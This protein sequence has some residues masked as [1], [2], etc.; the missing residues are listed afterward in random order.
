M[1][2]LLSI[3]LFVAVLGLAAAQDG[4]LQLDGKYEV[5]EVVS[6]GLASP[7]A[8]KEIS[9]VIIKDGTLTIKLT[10]K[11]EVMKFKLHPSKKPA[12]IDFTNPREK[13]PPLPGIY[14]MK[15]TNRGL[16]L[17]IAIM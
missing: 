17:T 12:E 2:S 4:P 11:D 9:A 7:E 8:K 5:I 13:G 10:K 14:Q 1:R 15:E 3:S 6:E 16:E